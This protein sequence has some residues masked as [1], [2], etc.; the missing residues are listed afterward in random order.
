LKYTGFSGL[1]Y[2]SEEDDYSWSASLYTKTQSLYYASG[3]ALYEKIVYLSGGAKS[4]SFYGLT[5]Q[6]YTSYEV[7][8]AA[9]G[10]YT[11]IKFFVYAGQFY[12]SRQLDYSWSSTSQ[13]TLLDTLYFDANHVLLQKNVSFADGS[14]DVTYYG[15]TGQAYTSDEVDYDK[16]GHYNAKFYYSYTGQSY[17]SEED[18]YSWSS[19][20]AYTLTESLYSNATG[21]L[22]EKVVYNSDASYAATYYGVTGQSY[23]SYEKD[24][25]S[26]GRLTREAYFTSNGQPSEIDTFY[27]D[28]STAVDIYQVQSAT[29]L[30][31]ETVRDA[32]GVE[33][34]QRT[35]YRDGTHEI[36]AEQSGVTVNATTGPDTIFIN[37]SVQSSGGWG[38]T[39][40]FPQLFAQDI[41]R[42]FFSRATASD[43]SH[44]ADTLVLPATE[45]ADFHTF[46]VDSVYSPTVGGTVTTAS[47][48][49][50]LTMFGMT[51]TSLQAAQPDFK[52]V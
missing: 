17:V 19:T 8:Y 26:S 29:V 14:Y 48:G 41:V 30:S 16:T 15:V 1:A 43:A 25:N 3:G 51:M 49:D 2:V 18:L 9:S 5:G 47:N 45:F 35:D 32:N 6:T 33:L 34:S 39:V 13:Y 20:S 23:T 50:S 4:V 22:V 21:G 37:G 44:L 42:D 24:Y 40:N 52:F 36:D 12:A 27:A 28:G 7:D 38:V 11:A 10:H 31:Y 46:Y